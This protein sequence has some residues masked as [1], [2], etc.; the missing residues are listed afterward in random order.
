MS[1]F[2]PYKNE[3]DSLAMDDLTIENRLDRVSIYGSIQLT[4]D[5]VGLRQA[6]ELKS[7]IDAVV[8]ALEADKAL[9]E[10]VPVKPA[11]KVDNPFK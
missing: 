4:R 11:D 2:R 7:V 5:K 10:H 6:K 8:A 9:P 1:D 3:A